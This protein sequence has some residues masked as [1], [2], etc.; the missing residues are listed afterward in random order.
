MSSSIVPKK[1]PLPR[2]RQACLRCRKQKL[3]CDDTRPCALCVR[4]GVEC[5]ER[6]ENRPSATSPTLPE[7]FATSTIAQQ[8]GGERISVSPGTPALPTTSPPPPS[9]RARPPARPPS[10]QESGMR[11]PEVYRER[12][13]TYEVVDQLFKEHN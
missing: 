4:V 7:G 8:N 10:P 11:S 1:R 6:P 12:T 3:R 13:S 9:D 2:A 5:R